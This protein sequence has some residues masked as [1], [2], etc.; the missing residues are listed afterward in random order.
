MTTVAPAYLTLFGDTV[1]PGAR[2]AFQW[3]V[4]ARQTL[5]Q[6]L[7]GSFDAAGSGVAEIQLPY[8]LAYTG[9]SVHATDT[10]II[11]TELDTLRARIGATDL[12]WLHM[13]D[14]T[15]RCAWARLLN[16]AP[17]M[18]ATQRGVVMFNLTFQVNSFWFGVPHGGSWTLDS[19]YL[20]DSGLWFDSDSPVVLSTSP[21]SFT[22][23]NYGNIAVNN[24][25]I[26]VSAGA[27]NITWLIVGIAG[28]C[29]FAFGATIA[30]GTTLIVDCGRGTVLNNGV[31]A[32]ASFARTAN[33][34][35]APW[36]RLDPGGNVVT[37]QGGGYGS[38]SRIE[39]TYTDGW[40]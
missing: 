6:T 31:D 7:N 18:G 5:I 1:I 2:G 36:F 8:T 9:A 14:D 27:G 21:Q 37:V 13:A 39:F 35:I 38:G 23:T 33:H 32:F 15:N 10:S 17:V 12:L 25:G 20:F 28:R 29:E 16:V 22:V 24:T 11:A 3:P 19:G 30:A 4:Q 40:A 26:T 34:V